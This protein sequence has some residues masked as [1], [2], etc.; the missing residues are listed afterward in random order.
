[1]RV[2]FQGYLGE[3]IGIRRV[4]LSL[5][6]VQLQESFFVKIIFFVVRGLY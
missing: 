5:E 6:L 3:M 4:L 1:M 2:V